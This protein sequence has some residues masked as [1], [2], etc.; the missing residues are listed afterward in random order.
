MNGVL[1]LY[2]TEG[3]EACEASCAGAFA[4]AFNVSESS[5]GCVCPEEADATARFRGRWRRRNLGEHFPRVLDREN[6]R[7]L[8]GLA[9]L[10]TPAAAAFSARIPGGL[11][12][13]AAALESLS[14]SGPSAVA[15]S[16]GLEESEVG[17]ET[18]RIEPLSPSETRAAMR[19]C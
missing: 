5:V 19:L 1:N 14:A 7:R 10:D 12:G 9:E 17:R 6:I 18:R 15:S 3:V 16:F 11:D 4:A 13:G 8:R 2:T